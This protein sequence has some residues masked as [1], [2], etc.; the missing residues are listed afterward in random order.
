MN[1]EI[2]HCHMTQNFPARCTSP[3]EQKHLPPN[4]QKALMELSLRAKRRKESIEDTNARPTYV[5]YHVAV[6]KAWNA[7]VCKCATIGMCY[8]VDEP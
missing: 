4:T 6:E 1:K 3:K 2:R 8:R 7:L 5:G